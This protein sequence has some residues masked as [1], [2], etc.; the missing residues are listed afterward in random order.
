MYSFVIYFSK[1]R[2]L[3]AN[4]EVLKRV[5]AGLMDVKSGNI[6]SIYDLINES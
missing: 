5:N 3:S 6:R 2:L 4:E 1:K